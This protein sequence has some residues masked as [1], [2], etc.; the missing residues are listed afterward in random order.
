[1]SEASIE[2]R[3]DTEAP[4]PGGVD[5]GSR[6]RPHTARN[7]ALAVGVVVAALILL[8]AFSGGDDESPSNALVGRRV[9]PLAGVGLDGEGI[10][11]DN[12]RGQWVVVNFF[13]TWCAPCVA[14]HPELVA[15]SEW[16]R[17]RGDTV[18]VSVVF[19]ETEE[20]VR[21]FF[22]ERGGD[23]PV[24]LDS[25]AA[26]DFQVAQVPETFLVAPDGTVAVHIPGATTFEEVTALIEQLG[27]GG[28]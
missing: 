4:T 12:Y 20:P 11:I 26:V 25:T 24:I 18:L 28:G 2:P 10:D 27:G 21:R 8:L 6:P 1:M 22:T 15:L 7:T 16:G 23:W 3:P 17:Q 14:E 9:P 13:A 5:P 19:N